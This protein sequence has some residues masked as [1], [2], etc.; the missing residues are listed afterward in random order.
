MCLYDELSATKKEKFRTQHSHSHSHRTSHMEY[1]DIILWICNFACVLYVPMLLIFFP[2][3]PALLFRLFVYLFREYDCV[4]LCVCVGEKLRVQIYLLIVYICCTLDK[5]KASSCCFTI[6]C[7][8]MYK[9]FWKTNCIG[10]T[11]LGQ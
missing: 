3:N 4:C 8:S 7:Q 10:R 9:K 2:L 11:F 5:I 6:F 1:I